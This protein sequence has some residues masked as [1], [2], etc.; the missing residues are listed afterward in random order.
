VRCLPLGA[1]LAIGLT[2]LACSAPPPPIV[3]T[4]SPT[5]EPGSLNVTALLDLSGSREPGGTAQRDALQL[6]ADQHATGTPRVRLRIV[7]LAGS[8]SKSALELRRAAVEDA[9]DAI[10]IGASVGYDDAF[11][12]AVQITARPVLFTLPIA[13]PAVAGG[14]WA[15]ALAPTPAQLARATLDDAAARAALG[16]TTVV[17]DE[18]QTAVVERAALSAE[19]AK[20]GVSP[21]IVKVTPADAMRTVRPIVL[22]TKPVIF[23]GIPRTYAEAARGAAVGTALYLSYICDLGDVAD[24]RDAAF[25]ATW[26]GSRWIATAMA[27]TASAA[28]VSF[29]QSYTDRAGPPTSV[30]ASA[31]DA[32]GLL[33]NAAANGISPGD[34]RDR[35]ETGPYVGVATTYSFTATR[36]AGFAAADLAMLRFVGPRTAPLLR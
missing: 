6:W 3:P 16:V 9:A 26:P 34:M 12:S 14:G 21:T 17:S 11:A 28:R 2:V 15:F 1:A 5:H 32:L 10:I 30:A 22:A 29:V 4:P 19:L 31:Y 20:R 18:S 33:A 35:L 24:F 13:D 27:P 8:P 7:D 23:A 36:R 25:L